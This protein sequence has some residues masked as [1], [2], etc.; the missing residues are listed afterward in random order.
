MG[1]VAQVVLIGDYYNEQGVQDNLPSRDWTI[2]EEQRAKRKYVSTCNVE[3]ND[4]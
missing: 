3:E 2:D 4:T 1:K